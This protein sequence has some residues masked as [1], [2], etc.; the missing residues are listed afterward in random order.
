MKR[1]RDG[2]QTIRE[3]FGTA[4]LIVAIVALVAALGGGA[5]AASGGGNGSGSN[6]TA[7][8]GSSKAASS[9]QATASAKAKKGPRGPKGPK[10]DTGPAG[11]AGPQGPA[12]ANGKAGANGS[13]GAPG[14]S[15]TIA[16]AGAE[17]GAVGGTKFS[18]ASGS[19]KVCNGAK[20]AEGPAGP[21]C[22]G[23]ECLLPS[24]A[25]EVGTYAAS[26][27]GDS[28]QVLTSITF[29]LRLGEPAIEVIYVTKAEVTGGS[30][31]TQCPGS[32]E[33]PKALPGYICIYEKTLINL[34]VPNFSLTGVD[35]TGG[36]IL[37][38]SRVTEGEETLASGLWAVTAP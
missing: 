25:T 37:G 30:A 9:S 17:C 6:A 4:G 18:N 20:G 11:P 38:M 8:G 1:L 21:T 10:G 26:G 15:V 34:G 5:Y 29:P 24:G 7:D 32:K 13:N 36:L 27:S 22:L 33:D 31:P 28:T 16:S 14:E 19:G 35:L 12:G 3:P 23:G 2:I